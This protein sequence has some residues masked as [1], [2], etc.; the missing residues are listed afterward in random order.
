MARRLEDLSDPISYLH[1]DVPEA[2]KIIYE[3]LKRKNLSTL[4]FAKKF[5]SKFSRP[6][7]ALKSLG[8]VSK[9]AL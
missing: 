1:E 6:S 9:I 7:A 2:S 5:Y 3:K 8:L 4:D